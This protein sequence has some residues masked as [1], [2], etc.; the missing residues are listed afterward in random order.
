M[1]CSRDR[2]LCDSEKET[3]NQAFYCYNAATNITAIEGIVI[4]RLECSFCFF[5]LISLIA[6]R[7]LSY[8]T[9]EPA[10]LVSVV[11]YL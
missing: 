4:I 11:Y 9:Q 7:I 8:I 6:A 2:A 3:G 5:L 10:P 1:G